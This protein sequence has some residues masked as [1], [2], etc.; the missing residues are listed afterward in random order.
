MGRER[1]RV[2]KEDY[3]SPACFML[4]LL[5]SFYKET[6]C[7]GFTSDAIWDVPMNIRWCLSESLRTS[8]LHLI[9]GNVMKKNL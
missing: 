4:L 6:R 3:S 1:E 5:F 8:W 7:K 9:F 2:C